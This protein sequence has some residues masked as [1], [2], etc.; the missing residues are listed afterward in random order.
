MLRTRTEQTDSR[1]DG[2]TVKT[3]NAAY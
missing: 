3:C 1:T 2:R